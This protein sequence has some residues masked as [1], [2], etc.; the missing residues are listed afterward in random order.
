LGQALTD[1]VHVYL[2]DAPRLIAA[3]RAAAAAGDVEGMV[4]PA[5]S[6]KSSS[7]NL[8]ATRLSEQAR[9]VEHGAR[10][11]TL[12]P[13]LLPPV[14]RIE[15]EFARVRRELEALVGGKPDR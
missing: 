10:L 12:T 1:L 15:A 9:L 11:K 5:H 8:G 13:P 3:L 4:G 2:A 6:L 14:E 7:A